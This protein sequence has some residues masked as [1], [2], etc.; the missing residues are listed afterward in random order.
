MRDVYQVIREKELEITQVRQ[1]IEALRA[2]LPLLA[3][4]D[5]F[6]VV[7]DEPSFST[8][9]RAVNRD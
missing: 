8:S 4:E 6:D 7:A 2:I 9:P 1:E 3:D 5:D